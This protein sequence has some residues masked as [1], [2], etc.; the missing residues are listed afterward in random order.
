MLKIEFDKILENPSNLPLPDYENET[1]F[2][3]TFDE[4]FH[5]LIKP[6]A[7]SGGS[8]DADSFIFFNYKDESIYSMQS[9]CDGIEEPLFKLNSSDSLEA[10]KRKVY[11]ECEDYNSKNMS[12][13]TYDPDGNLEGLG[14]VK[15]INVLWLDLHKYKNIKLQQEIID[16]FDLKTV[17]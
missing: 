9:L 7:D 2:G 16:G 3:S 8:F 10:I 1:V 5:K 4:I 15:D 11:L 6:E 12:L 14:D 13:L 17:K